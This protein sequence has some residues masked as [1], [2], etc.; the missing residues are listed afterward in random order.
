MPDEVESE[1]KSA[2]YV[3][4]GPM[5]QGGGNSGID[6]YW[7]RTPPPAFVP[8]PPY[9]PPVSYVP[10]PPQAPPP[11]FVPPP[12]CWPPVS[13]VLPPPQEYTAEARVYEYAPQTTLQEVFVVKDRDD[14]IDLNTEASLIKLCRYATRI[15]VRRLAKCD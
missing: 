15:Y 3:R 11:N 13:Y 10:P 14:L 2:S 1:G 4:Y 7:N 8:P 5:P 12:P 6:A 9:L